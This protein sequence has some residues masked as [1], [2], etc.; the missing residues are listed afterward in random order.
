MSQIMNDFPETTKSRNS[1]IVRLRRYSTLLAVAWTLIVAGALRRSLDEVA[2][3]TQKLARA[4]ARVHFER[5]QAFRFWATSHGGVYVPI[6]E[7]TQPNPYLAHIPDR[8]ISKPDGTQLTLMNPAYM[9]RQMNELFA[10]RHGIISHVTSLQPLRAGN[11]ADA[12]EK[13]ALVEFEKGKDEVSEFTEID[14]EPYLRLIRPMFVKA[15]CLKC[16]AAQGYVKGDVRGGVGV[17]L[18]LKSFLALSAEH[19]KSDILWHG[20]LWFLGIAGIV[21]GTGRLSRRLGEQKKVEDELRGSEERYRAIAEDMPVFVCRFLSCGML[22]YVNQAYCNYCEKTREALIGK[23]FLQFI[24]EED[25]TFVMENLQALTLDAPSQSLE[26]SVVAPN[27]EMR[28]QRW[29]NRALFTRGGMLAGYQAIG[30]DVTTRKQAEEALQES[31]QQYRSV[32]E[33]VQDAIFQTDEAGR[34]LFLNSAWTK[35]TG[36][37]LEESLDRT[38]SEFV[39]P[40]DRDENIRNYESLMSQA[41]A[42]CHHKIRYLVKGGGFRWVEVNAQLRI[43]DRGVPT[44]SAGT[45][46]DITN[47]KLAEEQLSKLSVAIEQSPASVMI[48]DVSGKIEYVNRKFTQLTGYTF[49]EVIGR[50]PSILQSGKTSLEE[51]ERLWKTITSGQEWHGEFLNRKKSGELY[52]ESASINAI[53]NS[54]NEITHFVAVK[55]D[56]TA[57]KVA[58]EKLLQSEFRLKEAEKNARLGHWEFDMVTNA[59]HWSDE[60]LRIFN[61]TPEQFSGSYEAFLQ[62]VHPDDLEKLKSAFSDSFDNRKP[63]DVEHRLLLDDGTIK[64][65][66]E[67][68]IIKFDA[69]GVAISSVGTVQ[70]VTEQKQAE[71][72]R[73]KLEEQ[74]RHAHK[75]DTMGTLAGGIAHDFNNILQAIQGYVEMCLDEVKEGTH[76]HRDLQEVMTATERAADTIRRILA[77]SRPDLQDRKLLK[78]DT[79]VLEALKLLKASMPSTVKTRLRLDRNCDVVLANAGQIHQVVMN[80]C[81]NAYQAMEEAGGVLTVRL[82]MVDV[83]EKLGKARPNLSG[84]RYV[85]L[86]VSDTGIGMNAKIRERIFEPFFTTRDVGMGTGLGLA[87]VHGIVAAHGGDIYVNSKPG[88]GT[89]FAVYLP[90]AGQ[91]I[92]K[93]I[94]TKQDVA[95]GTER[96]LFIDDEEVVAAVMKRILEKS[97]YLVVAMQDSLEALQEFRNSPDKFDL[98]ITDQTMPGMTGVKLAAELRNIRPNIPI[99]LMSGVAQLTTLERA[100]AI[101]ITEFLMKP[102]VAGELNAAIRRAFESVKQREVL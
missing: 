76:I 32:V 72:A 41:R 17:A 5:D 30:E 94:H 47:R 85:R 90:A 98:V 96:I 83:D 9:V 60:T 51:Y 46:T 39:H 3:F 71:I 15:A 73:I 70:D 27:G 50:N 10:S 101:G 95:G 93:T 20:V 22:T 34:W 36:F 26:H 6:D 75:M 33:R 24:P 37:S 14:G 79:V 89:R 81:A 18:P 4:E 99:I 97:G 7:N 35:I 48:T 25:R 59:L 56:I 8:D 86:T 64:Y 77:F 16:H 100:K 44:G 42:S 45:L 12:W 23:S 84:S 49:P 65:V 67:K 61:L 91:K 21:F 13:A 78:V 38:F 2:Q 68:C 54:E 63:Y 19:K 80:L 28:W 53:K 11:A 82:S 58:E 74:L 102:V 29:T 43:D 40:D 69:E 52:W 92:G 88:K 57:H 66:H 87:V 31:E 62:R 1:G 55:I